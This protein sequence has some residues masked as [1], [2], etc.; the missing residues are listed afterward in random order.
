VV[1][2]L[3]HLLGPVISDGNPDNGQEDRQVGL[4]LIQAIATSEP[5]YTPTDHVACQSG[6]PRCQ[7]D[8]RAFEAITRLHSLLDDDKN[9]AVDAAEAEG[10]AREELAYAT[11][12]E[13]ASAINR[14]DPG[15]STRELWSLWRASDTYNWTADEV[16]AWT[17]Q[18]VG[19]PELAVTMRHLGI[20]GPHLPLLT[21]PGSHHHQAQSPALSAL[22]R[23]L[24]PAH[25]R[26]LA[27]KAMDLVLFGPP[28]K[29]HSIVK[30]GLLALL[31]VIILAGSWLVLVQRQ[32]FEDH[33]LKV[34]DNLKIAEQSLTDLQLKL[35]TAEK[36]SE[37]V[38]A[39]KV[40]LEELYKREICGLKQEQ[41]SHRNRSHWLSGSQSD[42]TGQSAQ[43]HVTVPADQ[44]EPAGLQ[45]KLEQAEQEVSRLR[46]LLDQTARLQQPVGFCG[47]GGAE[48]QHLLQLSYETELRY[49][50]ANRLKA[51]EQLLKASEGLDR[52]KRKQYSVIGLLR[53]AFDSAEMVDIVEQDIVRAKEFADKV[54]LDIQERLQRWSRIEQ[55]IGFSIILPE[56]EQGRGLNIRPYANL[57]RRKTAEK[58]KRSATHASSLF[59]KHASSSSMHELMLREGRHHQLNINSCDGGSHHCAAAVCS[60]AQ[61]LPALVAKPAAQSSAGGPVAVKNGA[62]LG[63][64]TATAVSFSLPA[65]AADDCYPAAVAQLPAQQPHAPPRMGT[66]SLS[67]RHPLASK[68]APRNAAAPP[69]AQQHQAESPTIESVLLEEAE[70]DREEQHSRAT[71]E[72]ARS[73]DSTSSKRDS[74]SG[75]IRKWL[76]GIRERRKMKAKRPAK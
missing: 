3:C 1:L 8:Q 42:S 25:R 51:E 47:A 70:E 49:C 37:K 30:D 64:G 15:V 4:A 58:F 36:R 21:E 17:E 57:W 72:D 38:R 18:Q 24:T 61:N 35:N 34:V 23:A 52:L 12:F 46:V 20:D 67:G 14:E 31:L 39:E 54:K 41:A 6:N 11:D 53:N 65:D 7:L 74:S 73:Q 2:L 28:K 19:L 13:R 69:H 66:H 62:Q 48:L 26:R 68:N 29:A 9:G 71:A 43:G 76:N 32:F 55:L 60:D 33:R 16:S 59:A 44:S 50:N 5:A 45:D 27:I 56:P 75:P 10:F 63:C 40:Q 22:L